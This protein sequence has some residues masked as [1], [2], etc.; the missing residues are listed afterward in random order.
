MVLLI[1]EVVEMFSITNRNTVI[2][3]MVMP[4][5]VSYSVVV[6]TIDSDD[7]VKAVEI[8][9]YIVDEGSFLSNKMSMID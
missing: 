4:S 5:N 2:W 3:V 9:V 7:D 6:R 1:V 8:R